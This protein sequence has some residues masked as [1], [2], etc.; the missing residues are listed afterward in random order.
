LENEKLQSIE[1]L[2][3]DKMTLRDFLE[4]KEKTIEQNGAKIK[5]LEVQAVETKVLMAQQKQKY[6]K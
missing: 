4:I 1:E 6:D 3:K 5:A 2:K